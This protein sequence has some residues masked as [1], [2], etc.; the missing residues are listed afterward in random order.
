MAD[1]LR[2]LYKCTKTYLVESQYGG[3]GW[4]DS[5]DGNIDIVLT[6]PNGW[7]GR[8]QS[9]MRDAAVKARLVSSMDA[10]E[11]IYF[12]TEGEASL[13]FCVAEGIL[14]GIELVSPGICV[15]ISTH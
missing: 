9:L 15:P 12:V 8:Q 13:H 11:R 14:D 2:Y 5:L 1:F 6:H 7:G 4:W 3:Q 10:T